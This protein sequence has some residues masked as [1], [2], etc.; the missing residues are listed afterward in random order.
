MSYVFPSSQ[1]LMKFRRRR[2]PKSYSSLDS[3]MPPAFC[4]YLH[5][6]VGRTSGFVYYIFEMRMTACCA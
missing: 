5:V 4:G 1:I 6:L 2:S 3:R